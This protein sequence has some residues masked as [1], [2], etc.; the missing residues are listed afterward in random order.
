MIGMSANTIIHLERG[1]TF[2]PEKPIKPQAKTVEK[3]AKVLD[4]DAS[5]L[6]DGYGIEDATTMRVDVTG[7]DAMAI[8]RLKGY[9]DGL[10]KKA[11]PS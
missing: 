2:D 7:L 1:W 4:M 10:K 11:T 3:L 9:V 5:E 6:L 8:E